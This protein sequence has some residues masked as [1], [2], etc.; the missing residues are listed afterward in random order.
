MVLFEKATQLLCLFSSY[1]CI[2][3]CLHRCVLVHLCTFVGNLFTWHRCVLVYLCTCEPVYFLFTWHRCDRYNH[4]QRPHILQCP[5]CN[6]SRAEKKSS[7]Q[8]FWSTII[9]CSHDLDLDDQLFSWSWSSSIINSSCLPGRWTCQW[10]CGRVPGG[11]LP[12]LPP[13][14]DIDND[15]DN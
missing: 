1:I 15:H 10:S 5:H 12:R 14:P 6:C 3:M 13:R 8:W 7:H 11:R 4:N 2:V 9:N